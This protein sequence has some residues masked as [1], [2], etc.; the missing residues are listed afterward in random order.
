MMDPVHFP[1]PAKFIPDRFIREDGTF[2]N[3]P[4]VCVFSIGLRNCVG[5]QLAIAEYFHF[6]AQIIKNFKIEKV[7]G[8]L[9]PEKH[10][11]LLVP[12]KFKVRFLERK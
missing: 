6:S 2:F 12:K 1:D 5:K 4:R 3:D 10:A 8:S 7:S 11:T 9:E